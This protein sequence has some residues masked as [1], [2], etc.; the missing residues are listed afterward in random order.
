[1]RWRLPGSTWALALP[2]REEMDMRKRRAERR[3]EAVN[4][5]DSRVRRERGG[6]GE[7]VEK[8]YCE[9]SCDDNVRG[10]GTFY[11]AFL[12]RLYGDL[13]WTIIEVLVV[14]TNDKETCGNN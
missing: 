4:A 11:L 3:E 9:L 10:A 14:Q 12:W 8:K 13:D 6:G 5:M 2:A 1:M 7:E